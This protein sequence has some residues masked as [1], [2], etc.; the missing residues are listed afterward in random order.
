[1][2]AELERVRELKTADEKRLKEAEN[3]L[4]TLETRFDVESGILKREISKLNGSIFLWNRVIEQV[5]DASS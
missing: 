2:N 1:L 3:A 4:K 5:K